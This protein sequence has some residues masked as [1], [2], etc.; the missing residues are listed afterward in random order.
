MWRNSNMQIPI[1]IEDDWHVQYFGTYEIFKI[2]RKYNKYACNYTTSP[3][4]HVVH[5]KKEQI[6]FNKGRRS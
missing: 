3:R 4:L 2:H 6:I 5:L 1:Q